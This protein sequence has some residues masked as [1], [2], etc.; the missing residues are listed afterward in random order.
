MRSFNPLSASV[1]LIKKPANWFAMQIGGPLL[2]I[3]EKQK[4]KIKRKNKIK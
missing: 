1:A 2:P 3:K 4:I